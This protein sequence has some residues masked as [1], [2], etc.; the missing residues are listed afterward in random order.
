MTVLIA[1]F[2]NFLVAIAK[3]VAAVM[4]GSASMLAEAAHSWSD[5]GN[6]VFLIIADKRAKK[7]RDTPHPLGYGREA[8]VW[9]MFAAFGI[10]TVGA[11]VS[12]MHGVRELSD[13]G[14]VESPV[15]AYVVLAI[16]FVLEGI[17]FVQATMH[18][19]RRARQVGVSSLRMLY[20]S[21]DATLRA[22]VFEDFAAIVGLVIA[23]S[24]IAL[25]QLTG[26]AMW[27]AVG[28]ILIGLL[29][30]L[31]AL[32]LIERNRHFLVG[33]A[34][35]AS[36]RNQIGRRLLA[37]PEIERVTYLHLEY[38][39]PMRLF[40]VAEVD[41]VGNSVE[42]DVAAE[43]RRIEYALEQHEQIEEAVLS[44][45][46]SDEKSLKFND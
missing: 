44:L 18:I 43:L 39:G 12:V 28:S 1:F 24:S 10:F 2:A 19:R 35:S 30:G 14:P 8:Y 38:I 4:T 32:V 33:A 9:S 42:D 17:S 22:V 25:H 26:N 21:S 3:T 34:S 5:A 20:S 45:S 11:V 15:V 31:V 27:D 6:E 7:P 13:P 46:V 23:A 36:L 41:L 40:L 16:A 29:L 37:Q